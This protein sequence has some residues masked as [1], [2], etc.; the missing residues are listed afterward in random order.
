MG[1]VFDKLQLKDQSEILVLNAPASFEPELS[2]LTDVEV[3]RDLQEVQQVDFALVFV[4]SRDQVARTVPGVVAQAPG[5]ATLWFAYPKGSS[6]NY[7]SDLKRDVGWEP[8]AEAGFR[9]VRQV[10][11]DADWSALRFRRT[12]FVGGSARR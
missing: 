3:V 2:G 12:E 6:K 5:D 8:L 9:P 1:T 4:T 7:R 11:V 10:A